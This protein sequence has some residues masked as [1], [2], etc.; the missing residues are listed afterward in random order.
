VAANGPF[1]EKNVEFMPGAFAYHLHSFS[2]NTLR[3]TN[4]FWC[5]PLLARGATCTMGCVYEPYLQFMPNIAHFAALFLNG[6]TFGEAAWAS[7]D[8]L[9][10]QTTV[11]GDPLYQPFKKAPPALHAE[12]EAKQS[13]LV[14]WSYNRL[15]NLDLV[16]GVRAGQLSGFLESLPV[17]EQSAVLTEKLAQL[18]DMQ[19]KPASAIDAWRR[20]LT[21]NP[22]PHQRIRLHLILAEKLAAEG[23]EADMAE[24][25]RQLIADSPDYPGLPGIREKLGYLEHKLAAEKK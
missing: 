23:R 18:Y 19:G 1:L 9:S 8:A 24:N 6:W 14:E 7:E 13:P 2:A 11:I 12:L 15:M 4:Q 3:T 21:L 10:W 20:A 16:H 17:T 22:S 5:G 25:W